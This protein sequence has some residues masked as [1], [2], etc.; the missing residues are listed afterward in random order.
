MSIEKSD[1]EKLSHLARINISTDIADIVTD[2]IN[3]V[4]TMVDQL[5]AIDT[6]NVE[7]MAHPNDA[8][9]RLRNDEVSEP[10]QRRALMSNAPSQEDGL[11]LVPKVID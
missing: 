8:T 7:P 3:D 9:Q 6:D 1:I 10:D 4:L 11:F 5:Q 2:R